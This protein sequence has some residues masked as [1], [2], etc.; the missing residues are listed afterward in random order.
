MSNAGDRSKL[1]PSPNA[2]QGTGTVKH[3]I[4]LLS[5]YT[6]IAKCCGVSDTEFDNLITEFGMQV[7]DVRERIE[8]GSERALHE[9]D[10]V[11]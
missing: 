3:N 8:R 1:S 10:H 11:I 9:A 4:F 7:R 6:L 5:I 2:F